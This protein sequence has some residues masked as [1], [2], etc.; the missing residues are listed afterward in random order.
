MGKATTLGIDGHYLSKFMHDEDGK[1]GLRVT[2]TRGNKWIA[3]GDGMLL[4]ERS[5]DNLQYVIEATQKSVDQ[6]YEAF[7]DPTGVVDTAAVTNIIPFVD[8]KEKNNYPLFQVK[9]DGKLHMRSNI[10]DLQDANTVTDWWGPTSA[11]RYLF[12]SFGFYKPK[13]S[14]I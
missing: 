9:S 11:L 12:G 10:N 7:Q 2:N 1:F 13:N 8:D 4:D 5:K 14:V 3:Y 6:V